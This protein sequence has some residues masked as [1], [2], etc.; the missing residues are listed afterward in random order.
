MSGERASATSTV[1]IDNPRMRVTEWRFPPGGAT[2]RH[3]HGLD[4][5]I[6]PLTTGPL[7]IEGKDG[8]N[9]VQ[10]EAGKSYAR[11]AGVEHDV[12]NPNPFEFAFIEIELK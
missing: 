11:E 5:C 12:I 9:I 6:V 2:G 3:R 8:S 1:Q 4:Y 10:L 7:L